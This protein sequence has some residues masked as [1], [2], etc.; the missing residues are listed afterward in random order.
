MTIEQITVV[1]EAFNRV[2]EIGNSLFFALSPKSSPD[3]LITEDVSEPLFE[4]ITSCF[5]SDTEDF[6][7]EY[8][9]DTLDN[10]LC[11]MTTEEFISKWGSRLK[12]S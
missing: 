9:S 3:R 6:R 11:G 7:G 2:N 5:E 12:T 10:N 8:G 1:I 4:L